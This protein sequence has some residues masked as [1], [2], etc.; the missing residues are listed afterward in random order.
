MAMNPP[1]APFRM[2]TNNRLIILWVTCSVLL[3]LDITLLPSCK[4]EN[5]FSPLIKLLAS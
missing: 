1:Q 2:E 4:K 3:P 5:N